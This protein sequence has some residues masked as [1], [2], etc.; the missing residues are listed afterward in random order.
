MCRGHGHINRGEGCC[1]GPGTGWFGRRFYSQ[2]EEKQ[3]LE[4][5][6]HDL[7]QEL[8]AVTEE[9]EKSKK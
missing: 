6:K 8:A 4:D 2:S 3:K 9:I 1:C 5:Y 7:E